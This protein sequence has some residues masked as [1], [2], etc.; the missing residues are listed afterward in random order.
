MNYILILKCVVV[1]AIAL[2]FVHQGKVSIMI[3]YN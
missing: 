3:I 2:R 1:E